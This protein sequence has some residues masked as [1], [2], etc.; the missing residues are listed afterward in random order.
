MQ[1]PEMALCGANSVPSKWFLIALPHILDGG[2]RL[3]ILDADL[4]GFAG[5]VVDRL[6]LGRDRS[7]G[8]GP[9][10]VGQ[11]LTGGRTEVDQEE[12][13]PLDSPVRRLV[14]LVEAVLAGRDDGFERALDPV[15][16]HQNI[17]A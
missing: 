14:V 8:E 6:H 13:S 10:D 5:G 4:G 11:V 7:H 12:V 17:Q 1:W 15:L 16:Q 3:Q 9:R 2:A